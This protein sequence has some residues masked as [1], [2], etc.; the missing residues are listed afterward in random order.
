MSNDVW[1]T[2]IIC[3]TTAVIAA[4]LGAC[5]TVGYR[6]RKES[7]VAKVDACASNGGSWVAG[8]AGFECEQRP[9]VESR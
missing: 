6:D 9:P 2:T 8:P 7:E 1:E 4:V 5:L 3:I